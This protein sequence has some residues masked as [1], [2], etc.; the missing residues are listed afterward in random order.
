MSDF[1][2]RTWYEFR[3][4]VYGGDF[5]LAKAQLDAHPGLI[6]AVNAT[7][8]TVLHFLAVEDDLDGVRWLHDNGASLDTKNRFGNPVV[9][10]VAVLEYRE[11][12]QWFVDQGADVATRDGDGLDLFQYL[13]ENE[14]DDMAEW[15]R[16]I[17]GSA[18]R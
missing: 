2:D 5:D 16:S 9:F 13:I 17:V 15:V 4:A 7:G 8:E 1:E 10:E 3:N 6:E 11:L 12:F 18:G 14:K